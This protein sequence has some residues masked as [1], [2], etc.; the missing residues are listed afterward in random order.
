[1]QQELHKSDNEI[2][3]FLTDSSNFRSDNL[4]ENIDTQSK[5][6]M[7]LIKLLP[8]ILMNLQ[9]KSK[10]EFLVKLFDMLY[11]N[12]DSEIVKLNLKEIAQSITTYFSRTKYNSNF[13]RNLFSSNFLEY[14]ITSKRYFTNYRGVSYSILS[15]LL[16]SKQSIDYFNITIL[17][18]YIKN[19]TNYVKAI[20]N[21]VNREVLTYSNITPELVNQC[22][23]LINLISDYIEVDDTCTKLIEWVTKLYILIYNTTCDTISLNKESKKIY[24]YISSK[25]TLNNIK[26]NPILKQIDNEIK[27]HLGTIN[28]LRLNKDLSNIITDKLLNFKLENTKDEYYEDIVRMLPFTI[29][30]EFFIG[31]NYTKFKEK[32]IP[33]IPKILKSED[34]NIHNKSKIILETNNKLFIENI[35]DLIN[36]FINIE[37]FNIDSGFNDKIKVR[38]KILNI[39]TE[40]DKTIILNSLTKETFSEFITLLVAHI[41]EIMSRTIKYKDDIRNGSRYNSTNISQLLMVKYILYLDTSILILKNFTKLNYENLSNEFYYKQSELIFTMLKYSLSGNIYN[42]ILDSKKKSINRFLELSCSD[43]LKEIYRNIYEFIEFMLTK[44]EFLRE[45]VKNIVFY[46]KDDIDNTIKTYGDISIRENV[47]IKHILEAYDKQIK[48]EIENSKDQKEKYSCDVPIEFMDPILFSVINDPIEIPEVKQIMDK[49]TIMNHLTFSETNPFTNK[50][51]TKEEL[52]EYNNDSEVR[53][54]INKFID[55]FKSWKE[56]HKI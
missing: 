23:N 52:L 39:I 26:Y 7:E 37:P 40:L 42:E 12:K 43:K 44:K 31:S 22:L 19:Y 29:N 17:P 46:N 53:E 4:L 6:E 5:N 51:L 21:R 55:S 1:M 49:Y 54:R 9:K 35:E 38:N 24:S 15:T 34:I 27:L 8:S 32:A 36:L 20:Y 28:I 41:D 30:E 45:I 33:I 10:I 2:L 18:K 56:K 11:L 50:G 16:L 13:P 47:T 25:F 48:L 3:K 14:L